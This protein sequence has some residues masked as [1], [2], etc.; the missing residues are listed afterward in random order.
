MFKNKVRTLL[1]SCV[2]MT[3]CVAMVVGATFSLWS[4]SV[5]VENH[6]I[7]GS[8][9]VK[10][11]RVSLSKTYFDN[12]T[13]C[14][15]T[16]NVNETVVDFSSTNTSNANVFGI[17]DGE[18]LVPGSKYEAKLKISNNGDVAFSYDVIVKLNGNSNALAKQLKIYINDVDKGTLNNYVEDG[19]AVI[20]TQTMKKNDLAKVFTIKVEFV[21]DNA[22]NNDAQNKEVKFDLL[23]NA[24]QLTSQV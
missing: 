3:L 14:L 6:L 24:T 10:L 8:L 1:M 12:E 4:D 19:K 20:S 5:K 18:K 22:I 17:N 11:E 2:M 9:K 7:A 13:G 21:N 15:V 16:P 23:V